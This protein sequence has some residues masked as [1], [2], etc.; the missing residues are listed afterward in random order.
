VEAKKTK[1]SAAAST[2][3]YLYQARFALAEALRFAYADSGI[4]VSLERFDD[5]SFEKDAEPL[6]LLQTKHHLSNA[7]D[8]TD[9]S[10]DLW[11]TLRI[12]S[13][14][15]KSDPS[16]PSR[17]RFGLVTTASAPVGSVAALLRPTVSN[18][19]RNIET[20]V[21]Q[22]TAAGKNSKNSAL[23]PSFEAFTAL[24][25]EMQYS[26]LSAIDVFDGTANLQ[27][28]ESIIEDR[29]KMIAPR[30]KV[31]AAREQLEGW[32]WGRIAKALI[33]PGGGT[34]SVL[35]IEARLDDIREVMKRDALPIDMHEAYPDD[36]ELE[37]LDEMTFVKQLKMVHLG[38][39]QIE[40]AKR[41]FY[42]ASTQRSRWTRENLLFD[43]EV[44]RFERT[45]IEEWEPHF[46]KMCDG[47]G[48]S[49]NSDDLRKA[50]KELYYWV[51]TEARFAFRN[52]THR[53]L[54]VGSYNMLA[55][56]VRVG[57]HR[58]YAGKFTKVDAG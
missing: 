54:S 4:E 11:K 49:A 58:D 32:W 39:Q 7:G 33:A 12:W 56:D 6:E 55:N 20:A 53:F 42:R 43:G 5:V 46:H 24:A 23:V 48:P 8:L 50:G 57:W 22:L 13:E 41:D 40:L 28:L 52:V 18:Q 19:P 29:L 2:A 31:T 36:T 15:V 30:G 25:P 14:K 37:A 44:G 3:G 21:S 47:L 1:F 38:S 17:I 45:L 26:L 16:L 34:V 9:T 27:D 35:E 10:S 51:E